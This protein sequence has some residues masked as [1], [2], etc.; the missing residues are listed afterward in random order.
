MEEAYSCLRQILRTRR[1]LGSIGF[2]RGGTPCICF[3]EAPLGAIPRGLVNP[4]GNSRYSG[5]GIMVSKSYIFKLGGRPVIYQPGAEYDLLHDLQKWR[6]MR[7]DLSSDPPVDFTWER[8]WRLCADLCDLPIGEVSVVVPSPDVARRLETELN[9]E[10]HYD[11]RQYALL[12]GD[13]ALYPYF[14]ESQP[15]KLVW[16]DSN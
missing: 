4:H 8:E 7:F 1:L 12:I 6:H 14:E 9:N 15:W 11:A 10:N 2:I 5:F 16:L 3:S 13:E